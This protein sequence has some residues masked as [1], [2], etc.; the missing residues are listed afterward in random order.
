MKNL[1]QLYEQLAPRALRYGQGHIFHAWETLTEQQREGLLQQVA[2]VDFELMH[3]L[4][5]K[6]LRAPGTKTEKGQFEPIQPIP[7]PRTKEE[8]QRHAQMKSLGEAFLRQNKVGAILVAGGQGS[9]LGFN[10]PKG[11]LSIGPVTGK[12]LFQ[13][14][15]EKLLALKQKYGISIPWYIMTSESNDEATRRYFRQQN[16]FGLPRSEV[17]FFVQGMMPALDE[18]GKLI[19]DR[20]DHIFMSPDGHGGTFSALQKSGALHDMQQRGIEQLFYFQVDNVLVKICDPVFLGYHLQAGAEMSAKVCAKRDPYEK[21][22]VIGKINGR[23]GVIEYS[24]MS[25]EEKLATDEKGNLLYNSGSIAIHL[26]ARSFIER[27]ASTQLNLPWHVAHK[28]IP[29]ID[30]TGQTITPNEPNGYKFEKF[31]FDALQYT[32]KSVIL[33]VDRSEEFSPVKNAE[34]EDSPQTAQQDMTRLFAR[35]LKQAGF[36]I[37]EKSRALNQLKL[38]ISPL[39]AL[40]Q[41]EFLGKIGGKIVIQKALYL[42]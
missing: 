1:K 6:Y 9:R 12:S 36:R 25:D 32:S 26:L 16:Y 5:E 17:F 14:H 30:E 13:L 2:S 27:I 29:V 11:I 7:L 15:A 42:G 18:Q 40:D 23:L 37:P 35:W 31:V 3:Q 34:G 38:E 22:G 10:G 20:P 4:Y 24:D 39:Y 21:V 41:E 19:M 8:Q 28:K 33:E